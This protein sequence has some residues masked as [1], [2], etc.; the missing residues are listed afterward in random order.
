MSKDSET[1]VCPKCWKRLEL[2]PKADLH[3]LE[4][5]G[6]GNFLCPKHGKISLEQY[7]NITKTI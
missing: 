7:V 4:E 6:E 3:E 2:D 5:K 1:L